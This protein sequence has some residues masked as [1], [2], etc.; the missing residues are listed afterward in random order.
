M[1]ATI[2]ISNLVYYYLLSF[3]YLLKNYAFII[4]EYA[5]LNFIKGSEII[6]NLKPAFIKFVKTHIWP[7]FKGTL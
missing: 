1:S 7:I 2:I 5:L 6:L 3:N 4:L